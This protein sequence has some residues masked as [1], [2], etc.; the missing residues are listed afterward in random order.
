MGRKIY[1]SGKLKYFFVKSLIANDLAEFDLEGCPQILEPQGVTGKL[2]E[3]K[4]LRSAP[5]LA[6]VSRLF[7]AHWSALNITTSILSS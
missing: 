3:N 7:A 1:H 2:L 6:A 5:V 4:D